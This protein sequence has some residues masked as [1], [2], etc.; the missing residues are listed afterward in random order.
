MARLKQFVVVDLELPTRF[1]HGNRSSLS[2]RSL[3]NKQ[4]ELSV[5]MVSCRGIDLVI[6][7]HQ[8]IFCLHG[9]W[10][11][12]RFSNVCPH[13]FLHRNRSRHHHS[14]SSLS[15]QSLAGEQIQS[16][17]STWFLAWEQIQSSSLTSLSA[18]SL[19]G[20]WISLGMSTRFLVREQIQSCL[21]TQFLAQ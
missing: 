13:G 2:I 16:C 14:L 9:L 10:S 5:H 19:V 18:Q 7:I 1:L 8:L 20:E 11:V 3:V 4:I 15:A 6:I 21:S 17:L 12:N